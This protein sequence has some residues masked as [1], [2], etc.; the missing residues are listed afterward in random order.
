MWGRV[1]SCS[2]SRASANAASKVLAI[3]LMADLV[4]RHRMG[5]TAGILAAS[6]SVA[7]PISSLVAGGLADVTGNARAIFAVMAVVALA[8]PP[9]VRRPSEPAVAPVPAGALEA[10]GTDES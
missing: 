10:E 6:G 5:A 4:P 2:C 9:F 3:P 8:L 1:W 7:A